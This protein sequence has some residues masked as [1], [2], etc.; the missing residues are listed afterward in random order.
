MDSLE[1]SQALIKHF[2]P[3]G[4]AAPKEK[5]S[6]LDLV[7]SKADERWGFALCPEREEG[8][9]FLGAFEAAMQRLI[10][11]RAADPQRL[12][13]LALAFGS[14]AT[15]QHPSYR[16]ALKKYSNSIVFEDLEISLYLITNEDDVI[17]LAPAEV[18]KYLRGLDR[19]IASSTK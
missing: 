7:L 4:F 11:A 5:P 17:V 19:R 18:N 1:L 13:G 6:G 9:A 14:T 12:L 8:T 3:Q 15:G 10:D 2:V 16:R